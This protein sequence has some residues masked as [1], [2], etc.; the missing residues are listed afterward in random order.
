[1]LVPAI[2]NAPTPDTVSALQAAL[3]SHYA[4]QD[5]LTVIKPVSDAARV[6]QRDALV[7]RILAQLG[8]GYTPPAITLTT[9]AAAVAGAT[10]IECSGTAGVVPGMTVTGG[11][12]APAPP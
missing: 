2:T 11:G 3:R 1:M 9:T 12:L 10:T 7:A 8:D 6:R 5:W 4:E